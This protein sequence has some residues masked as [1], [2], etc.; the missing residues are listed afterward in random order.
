MA[1][2]LPIVAVEEHLAI[3]SLAARVAPSVLEARGWPAPEIAPS[4]FRERGPLLVDTGDARLAAMDAAG[5]AIQVL[6]VAGTVTPDMLADREGLVFARDCNDRIAGIVADRPD[7]FAGLACVPAHLPDAAADELERAVRDLGLR[8]AIVS[9]TV[10]GGFLDDPRF[11]PLL[12]R[13]EAL[14][15]PIFL[16]PG[17]PPEPVV[18]AY[19]GG[20]PH[21]MGF[22]LGCY[23]W[24]WH[25]EVAIHALRLIV[26]GTLDRHPRLQLIVGH[27]GEGL[28][29]MMERIDQSFAPEASHLDDI[30]SRYLRSR[31][32]VAISGF[33]SPGGFDTLLRTFGADRILFAVDYPM[34][35]LAET[36]RFFS[37][38]DLSPAARRKISYENAARLLGLKVGQA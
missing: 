36:M 3:P 15:V 18:N 12:H 26:S 23:G 20:L 17:L 10:E 38:R 7:R 4:L 32:S 33:C 31:F 34:T 30:P 25:S 9:G 28:P 29:A 24:G 2:A 16:H 14:D 13:A 21:N 6:S 37:T 1:H 11:A 27:M 8:G 5:I 22:I 19:Y 35:D